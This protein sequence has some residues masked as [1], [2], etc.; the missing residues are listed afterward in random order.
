[1]LFMD[2][3]PVVTAAADLLSHHF[4]RPTRL[5]LI[6]VYT[7]WMD[8]ILRCCVFP[9]CGELPE[10]VIVKHSVPR[11]EP[12]HDGW[13][14]YAIL[15]DWAAGLYLGQINKTVPLGA[16]FYCA[17]SQHRIVVMEDLGTGTT[18][19]TFALLFGD[20]AERAAESLIEHVALL[21]QLHAATCRTA[22]DYIPIRDSL[23]NPEPE[24]QLYCNPWSRARL[25]TS[26]ED[27]IRDA[28]GRYCAAL[29]TVDVLPPSGVESEIALVTAEVEDQPG[30][31]LA[32]CKG[33]QEIPNDAI[34][35]GARLRL[36]DF[37][38]GGLRHALIE[39][40][41]GR[42][43]WGCHGRFPAD[44]IT[45]MD[46]VYQRELAQCCAAAADTKIYRRAIALVAARW[47]L[48]H[49]ASRLA[50][51]VRA[52]VARGPLATLRQQFLG[53]TDAF[54]TL[55]NDYGAVPVLA[56]TARRL[57]AR[58]RQQWPSEVHT[59]PY[60]PVF[61]FPNQL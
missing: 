24:S 32:Y 10:T 19:D 12:A 51:A 45:K 33:D 57:A 7:T 39:G 8:R 35:V 11:P 60:Y 6:D 22:R 27:E 56:E 1:M 26:T 31:F 9:P 44:L 13:H 49:V 59:I 47:H 52:D 53:W 5:T 48:F 4:G 40:M 2:Y 36:F 3:S 58:L 50:E 18:P 41:P 28:V 17:D 29:E 20:D 23:G 21:G 43:T 46:D 34:R 54:V 55:A 30:D 16:R 38:V 25:R 14:I 42:M 15:N 37:N 61:Q